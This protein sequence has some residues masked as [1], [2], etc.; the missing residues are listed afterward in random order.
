MVTYIYLV[1]KCYGNSNKV[2]V[3]KSTNT[4]V[5]KSVHKNTFGSQ[6]TFTIIDSINSVDRED[7]KLLESYW[8]EQFRNWRF[9][10]MNG[11]NGGGG[12]EYSS[13]ETRLKI[14]QANKGVSRGKGRISPNKG[15]K[16]SDETRLKMSLIRKGKTSG[17]KGKK[18]SEESKLKISLANKGRVSSNKDKRCQPKS[19]ETKL[20]M[21]LA[22]KG[23]SKSEEHKL[24]ILL[25][26]Q[27]RRVFEK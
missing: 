18:K 7:W 4:I 17:A 25:A 1:E 13:E 5:R 19:V 14:S 2:Y 20:K 21:S 15:K 9:E 12:P 16:F 8:I 10:M 22:A 26:K 27:Q 6:I 23:K 3:G 24:N 11:N